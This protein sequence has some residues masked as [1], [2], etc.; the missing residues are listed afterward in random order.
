MKLK[1]NL[2]AMLAATAIAG[3]MV[4]GCQNRTEQAAEQKADALENQADAVRAEGEKTADALENQGDRLDTRTDGVDPPAEKS[5][6]NTADAVRDSSE[7]KADAL[8][9]QADAVRDAAK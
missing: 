6:D 9:N 2:A 8:E 5:L 4:T 1:L 7:K 3:V